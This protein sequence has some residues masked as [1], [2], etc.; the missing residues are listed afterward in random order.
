MNLEDYKT[1]DIEM[2]LEMKKAAL[3]QIEGIEKAIWTDDINKATARIAQL[4]QT[5]Q[6]VRVMKN[7]K[8]DEANLRFVEQEFKKR[9]I[10]ISIVRIK[11]AD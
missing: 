5:M 9:G 1:E 8:H 3:N 11:K 6:K 10:D 4:Y 7:R 2:V